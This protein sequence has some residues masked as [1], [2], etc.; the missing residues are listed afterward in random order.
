LTKNVTNLAASVRQRL[1]NLARQRNEDFGLL[2]TKYALERLLFRIS[3]SE[4]QKIF[5]LKGALL[6]ELWTE[7]AH[8]PTR[9]ADFLSNG[10]ND[11]SR[12]ETI[13]KEICALTVDEDGLQFDPA[14]VKAQRIK[15]DADY[16]GVRV[17]FL[18]YLERARIPMQIDIG[19][20]DTITPPP[21]EISFPTILNG[22]APLLLTYPKETVVAEKFEAMVKLGMAN[23]RMKDLYDLRLLSQLFPF[24]GEVL[25]EA[26]VRTFE[27]RK[28]AIPTN[29]APPRA[30][31]AEFYEDESKQRQW[32]AFNT[33]NR[34]Y[35]EAVPLKRV[36]AD[37]ER[38]L[39]PL[40][41]GLTIAGHWK[42]SWPAGGPWQD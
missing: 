2:L 13:F 34:L 14:S 35:I 12:F 10:D 29:A 37:I 25:A 6:F 26:V 31:T 9:D 21:V 24:G 5:V 4:Y 38:F 39:M 3:Q 23:S 17:T 27:R 30:F 22:P 41:T 32:G 42:R 15:E 19:F 16:E 36:M 8:R 40:L 18:S 1:A 11:P 28:T 7:Q 33:K 20:G